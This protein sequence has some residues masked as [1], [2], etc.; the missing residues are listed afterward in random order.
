VV[1][2]KS[3]TLTREAGLADAVGGVIC[4]VAGTHLLT[5]EGPRPVELIGPG[6]SVLT[7]DN[8]AQEVR[9]SGY[10]R[11]SG[12]R[13]FA[14]PHLRPIRI[15]SGAMGEDRPEGDLLVSPEHQLLLRDTQ[16]RDLFNEPEVLVAAR[17]LVDGRTIRPEAG[18]R[19]VT[20]VHLL[21]ARHE[22]VWA[23]GV[24]AETFHPAGAD[25]RLLAPGERGALSGVA[26]GVERDPF[27]YGGYARRTLSAPEAAILRFAA[28]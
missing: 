3:A 24:E 7:R 4:F 23:N 28:A 10:Q 21:T 9:W 15:R 20:Y 14:M 8:G 22:I 6:D 12:A 11:L 25:L 19:D 13:L 26:P 5:P 18:L 17:D 2:E 27:A 1:I 16:A